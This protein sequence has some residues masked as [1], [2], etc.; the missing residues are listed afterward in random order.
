MVVALEVQIHGLYCENGDKT[1]V[2]SVYIHGEVD[3]SV[4]LCRH[5][6]P[7]VNVRCDEQQRDHCVDHSCEAAQ[8]PHEF[9]KLIAVAQISTNC[10]RVNDRTSSVELIDNSHEDR[11]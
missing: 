4:G 7:K 3:Q 6:F 1:E 8:D 10:I 11:R 5:C 9:S 2:K